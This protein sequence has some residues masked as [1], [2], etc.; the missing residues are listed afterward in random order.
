MTRDGFAAAA[1]VTP[2]YA[3]ADPRI[4]QGCVPIDPFGNQPIPQAAKDYSF[5][6]LDENLDYKQEVAAFDASG[7]IWKGMGAG[8]FQLA[9]GSSTAPSSATTSARRTAR[10][11]GFARTI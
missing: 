1:A 5:G 6:F 9:A 8:P 10:P 7:D 4:A 3:L 2:S 11:T